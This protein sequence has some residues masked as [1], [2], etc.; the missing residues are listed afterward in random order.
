MRVMPGPRG[1]ITELLF[2]HWRGA[3]ATSE[4]SAP[5]GEAAEP[6]HDEDLQLALY[7]C[8]EL[9][10]GGLPGVDERWE[11]NPSLLDL[12]ARLEAAFESTLVSEV[13]VPSDSAGPEEMDLALRAIA[14]ADDGP[15]LSRYLER[16]A[17]RST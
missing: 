1:P 12:R 17:P 3:P 10:Y 15:S 8:Y 4:M 9:H 14:E 16:D 7:C 11:W 13:G 6:L 5:I 2:E